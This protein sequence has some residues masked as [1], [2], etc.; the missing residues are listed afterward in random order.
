MRSRSFA[1]LTRTRRVRDDTGDVTNRPRSLSDPAAHVEHVLANVCRSD[2][3]VVTSM[4]IRSRRRDWRS[5]ICRPP[6]CSDVLEQD[7]SGLTSRASVL[8][9]PLTVCRALG[10]EA[11][12]WCRTRISRPR[13]HQPRVARRA[14]QRG[15]RRRLFRQTFDAPFF[16]HASDL[17]EYVVQNDAAASGALEL[18]LLPH[19]ARLTFGRLDGRVNRHR[20]L[21]EWAVHG[22]PAPFGAWHIPSSHERNARGAQPQSGRGCRHVG[23][24]NPLI[25]SC[26][27]TPD[28]WLAKTTQ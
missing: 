21:A 10:E 23:R 1:T 14:M 3:L 9:S 24:S 20:A 6:L 26:R 27:T 19:A 28:F 16:A 7:V 11:R 8:G 22:Q 5:A 2:L 4:G 15:C 18:V 25:A 12:S 17:L 13:R